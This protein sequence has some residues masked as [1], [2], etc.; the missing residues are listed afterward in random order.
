MKNGRNKKNRSNKRATTATPL[1]RLG[2]GNVF[3]DLGLP[4]PEE[5]LVKAK[6]VSKIADVIGKRR[7]T[8]A[9][10]GEIMGLPQPKVSEL[11][12]GRTE[13]YSVER[14]CR[15]LTRIGVGISFVLKDQPDWSRGTVDVVEAPGP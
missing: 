11:C 10:A 5:E 1:G 15:L 14:L 7:M 13:T 2:S 6:L 9:Q 4:N 8:Q 12:N 3:A